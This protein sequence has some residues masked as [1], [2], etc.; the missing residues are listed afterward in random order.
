M[1]RLIPLIFLTLP[2]LGIAQVNREEADAQFT[3]E[4]WEA[5]ASSYKKYLKKNS[6]D[7]S[8]WFN[9]AQSQVQLAD[10]SKAIESYTKAEETNFNANF[11]SFGLAKTYALMENQTEALKVLGQAA[12]NGFPAYTRLKNAK[13]FSAYRDSQEYQKTLEKI[14]LNAYPC[15][16][17]GQ[18]RHFDFWVGEWDVYV[19]Q[20]KVGENNI[21]MATGGCAVHESYTTAGNYAG[22]SINYFDPIDKKW[23]QHWVGAAGDVYNYLE[24]DRGD[25]MLRF[26]SPFMNA[27][28]QISLSRLTF[29][30]NDDGTVRQLFEGSTDNGQS[31][32]PAFDGLY[33]K[34]D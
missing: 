3:A 1:E 24:T 10:Y 12:E 18:Y 33:K 17:S 2:L 14:R 5:A 7:S 21:T 13:E 27:Q 8:A 9:L 19:G 6:S 22:Q 26:E 25:G 28:G 20:Q 30:L 34:K 15:L 23:H 11:I 32:S 16:S 4:K 29:T 31:W